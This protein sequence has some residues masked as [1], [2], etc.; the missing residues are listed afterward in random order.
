MLYT[1]KTDIYFYGM[2]M[3]VYMHLIENKSSLMNLFEWSTQLNEED[4]PSIQDI[5]ILINKC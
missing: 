1:A 4:R 3:K 5:T 2:L